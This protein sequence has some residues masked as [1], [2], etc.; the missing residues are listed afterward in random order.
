MKTKE[1]T[2]T[3]FTPIGKTYWNCEGVYQKEY[4]EHY[5]WYVPN[6]GDA[7]TIHGELIRAVS[8]LHYDYFNNGNCNVQEVI[9][10]DCPDCYGTGWQ[11][12]EYDDEDEIDCSSCG[13]NCTWETGIEINEYYQRMIDFL[14]QYS[15]A[16]NEINELVEFL[17]D[18]Y[19][20]RNPNLFAEKNEQLYTRLVDKIMQQILTEGKD[21]NKPNPKFREDA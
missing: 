5:D 10:E 20:Y 18:Y 2:F 14:K 16:E 15:N 12:S 8:R 9:E 11:E 7:P 3:E 21:G 4:T 6:S 13:G 1:K 19:H 17:T